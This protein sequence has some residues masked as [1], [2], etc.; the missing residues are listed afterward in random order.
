GLAKPVPPAPDALDRKG[1]RIGIDPDTDPALVGSEVVDAVGRDLA[2]LGQREVMHPHWLGPA[3]RAQLA[4]GV[5]E[6][7]DQLLLLGINRD[8]RFARGDRRLHRGV[9]GGELG[10]A[11]GMVR[12]FPGFAIGL[13][14]VAQL[15]QQQAHQ[16]L[17]D[18]E[19][20]AE[21]GSG[22]LALAAA[23][24][25]ESV[26]SLRIPRMSPGNSGMKT[27]SIPT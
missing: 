2:L 25:A 1:G 12:P 21:E 23:D 14:A 5:L 6:V 16:L 8:G 9:D 26:A 18:L 7:A 11:V 10:V 22:D 24:P 15:T 17:A 13:A 20:A 19:A 27:P 3:L 4:A